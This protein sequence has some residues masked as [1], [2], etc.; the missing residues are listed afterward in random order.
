VP[1]SQPY[2]YLVAEQPATHDLGRSLP[3]N[4]K[5]TTRIPDILN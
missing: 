4:L 2:G 5:L 3:G 1:V